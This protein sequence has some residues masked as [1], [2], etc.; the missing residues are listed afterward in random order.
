MVESYIR[1][2]PGLASDDKFLLSSPDDPNYNCI[3][4]AYAMFKDRWMWPPITPEGIIY[5]PLDGYPWWP[6][7]VTIGAGIECLVEAFEKKGFVRCD[8]WEHENGFVKVALYY[9]PQN[10]YMTHAA[11][12]SRQ[13]DCWLS[14]L[15]PS[16]DI[17]HG[18]PY[19]IEGKVYGKVFCIMKLED[20]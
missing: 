4:W 17:H 11:R 20:K 7:G 13:H 14:K 19:T 9:N 18:T 16:H 1:A 8:S 12:E 15:G 10:G 6:E 2:F 5:Q 3:A